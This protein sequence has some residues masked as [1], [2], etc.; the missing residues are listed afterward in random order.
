[1]VTFRYRGR[2]IHPEDI[3]YVRALVEQHPTDSRRKLSTRLC[4]A[5]E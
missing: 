5:W 1:M 4:E 3:L 2:E